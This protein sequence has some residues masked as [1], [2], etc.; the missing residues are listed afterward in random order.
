[1]YWDGLMFEEAHSCNIN[2]ALVLKELRYTLNLIIIPLIYI[3]V[4]YLVKLNDKAKNESS[5]I[6][7]SH[8]KHYLMCKTFKMRKTTQRGFGEKTKHLAEIK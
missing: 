6:Y 5:Q 3:L 4:H 8:L 7:I 2:M 1:M